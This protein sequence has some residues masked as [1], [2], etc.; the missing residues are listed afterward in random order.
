MRTGVDF[1]VSD[2]QRKRLEKI[3]TSGNRASRARTKHARRAR[4]ILLTDDG[5]GTMAV[6]EGAGAS[7]P[8]VWRW[9]RRFMEEGV[10][11][12]PSSRQDAQVGD[13]A[14][15]RVACFSH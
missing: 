15:A 1:D 5:L 4:I 3:A 14:G 10:V 7:K 8:T 6:A 13:A 2:E 11:P 12:G 9:Q